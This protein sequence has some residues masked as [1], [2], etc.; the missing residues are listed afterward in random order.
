VTLVLAIAVLA[1]GG[2][3]KSETPAAARGFAVHGTV[4]LTHLGKSMTLTEKQSAPLHAGDSVAAGAA[5]EAVI[6][7]AGHVTYLRENGH[8]MLVSPAPRARED[9]PMRVELFRGLATFLVPRAEKPADYRFEAV[10]NSVVAAVKGTR[11]T[12]EATA[13]RTRIAVTSG[14]VDLLAVADRKMLAT[15]KD[16]QEAS[17]A[18]GASSAVTVTP[19]AADDLK[20]QT[21]E[22]AGMSILFEALGTGITIGVY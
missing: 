3:S 18:P 15:V 10:T 22:Q 16:G 6:E 17:A 13:D 12:V 11:F 20:R 9:A 21:R 19:M 8:L 4:T 7:S 5:S 1:A 2:C 14:S